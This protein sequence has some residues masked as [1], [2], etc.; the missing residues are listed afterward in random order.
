MHIH[1]ENLLI[2][3]KYNVT[4]WFYD[5]LDFPWELQ[6]RHWR[7]A[8]LG[9]MRGAVLEAGVGTGRN[10]RFYHHCVNRTKIGI[11]D[12]LQVKLLIY[13]YL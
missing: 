10:L 5:I 9:D 2:Q 7:P 8:L 13:N 12:L 4:A 3:A 1:E 6:Y 11:D